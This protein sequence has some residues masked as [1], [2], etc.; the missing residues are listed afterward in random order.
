MTEFEQ[1]LVEERKV[2]QVAFLRE[3]PEVFAEALRLAGSDRAPQCWRAA[4]VLETC[5]QDNDAR[6]VGAVD[7]LLAVLPVREDGHQR[8][9]MKILLRMEL[10]DE[11]EGRFFDAAVKIWEDPAQQ[12]GTRGTAMRFIL[13]MAQKYPDL[14]GEVRAMTQ[15]P[16]LR[17]LSPGIRHALQR[18]VAAALGGAVA[19]E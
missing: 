11:Q 8:E 7:G 1:V 9:L 10:G 19:E 18:Q 4:S 15:G 6:V 3:N 14:H 5:M 16:Y 12:P 17:S 2:G 13:K